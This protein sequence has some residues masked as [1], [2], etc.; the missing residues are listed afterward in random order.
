M[1]TQLSVCSL[2][3]MLLTLSACGKSPP[4][5]EVADTKVSTGH[6]H[7]SWWCDEHG[8]PEDQCAQ[9]NPKLVAKFKAAGDWCQKH[10]CPDS[11]CF[12]CHPENEAK[13]AK[14]YEEKT[15]QQPPKRGL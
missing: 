9:C 2:A 13:F 8:V 12:I 7:D 1:K 6:T 5:A 15:G 11:Q 14:L 3:V 4:P 10:D